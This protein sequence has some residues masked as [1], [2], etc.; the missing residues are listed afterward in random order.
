MSRPI[1][2]VVTP[3][4]NQGRFL[5]ETIDS[6]LSQ[7]VPGLEF[8]IVD[9]GSTDES[10]E[11]IKRHAR[12]FA[13]WVSEKDRGQSHAINKG[14]ARATGTWL[15]YLNSDDVYLPGAL[16]A[17]L[18]SLA[19]APAARWIAGGVIGWSLPLPPNNP[20]LPRSPFRRSLPS[21]P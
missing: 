11:V 19:T 15:A 16:P 3:S 21:P 10:V 1:I 18:A 17:L 20:S 13:W 14:I 8:I 7:G 6:V 9:G 12:H 4:Y 5:E 2:T